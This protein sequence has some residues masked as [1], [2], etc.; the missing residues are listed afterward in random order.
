MYCPKC[1]SGGQ[2]PESYCRKCGEFLLDYSGRSFLIG[3]LFGGSNP[4][5]QIY[6]N[7][8]L[9]IITIFTSALLA[10]FLNGYYDALKERTGEGVPNVI[11]LVYLFLTLIALWQLFSIVV[12]ARLLTKLGRKKTA[13]TA[14]MVKGELPVKA[15][16]K[17]SPQFE[18]HETIPLTVTEDSTRI[19]ENV[20]RQ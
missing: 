2:E 4:T 14:E 18:S 15:T 16:Q 5:T 8:I 6:S 9:N 3:R 10:G 12:G 17:L 20:E 1:G 13:S 19:L 7:L 11:Y